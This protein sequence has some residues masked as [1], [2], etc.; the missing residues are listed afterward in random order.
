M[1]SCPNWRLI[2]KGSQ[3]N[4]ANPQ[5][6]FQLHPTV[7]TFPRALC[8][9]S[10]VRI[11]SSLF[12]SMISS[13][14][15]SFSPFLTEQWSCVKSVINTVDGRNP[16]PPWMVETCWNPINHGMFTTYQLVFNSPGL[17]FALGSSRPSYGCCS[18]YTR[19]ASNHSCSPR[20]RRCAERP[21]G[22]PRGNEMGGP[23]RQISGG[24]SKV[25]WKGNTASNSRI[26]PSIA[27]IQHH[28]FMYIYVNTI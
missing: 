6:N 8:G 10:M 9:K 26:S 2:V 24:S 19:T 11:G 12:G 13:V 18:R 5:R 20:P 25:C 21:H 27:I 17:W 28:F 3:Y 7:S 16:A 1:T 4:A 14:F 22:R 15:A 23:D